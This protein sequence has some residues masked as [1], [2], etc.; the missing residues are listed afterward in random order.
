MTDM[1]HVTVLLFGP[2]ADAVGETQVE[3]AVG[4]PATVGSLVEL[5]SARHPKLA[6]RAASLRFAVNGEYADARTPLPDGAEVAVIPPVAGG[7]PT[8]VDL[9]E[10]PID[11][12]A[13][14]ARVGGL[15]AGAVVIF[16]GTV[17][18]EGPADNPLV[19]LEYTAYDAMALRLLERLRDEA[20]G[21]FEISAAAIVHRLGRL[22]VGEASVA[23]VVAAPHR[24]AA[25]EA[26]QWLID[27]LK[28]DVPIWKKEI[29]SRGESTWVEP[30]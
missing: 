26:C 21:R 3:Y 23:I 27:A 2:A 19:A 10:E 12:R 14:V 20:L 16:E 1:I 29:W 17:R 5:M 18:A 9:V 25:F 30:G 8:N 24:A 13:L 7:A 11:V 28:R 15:E 6:A 22:A 4:A